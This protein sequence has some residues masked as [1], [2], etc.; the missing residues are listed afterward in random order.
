[1]NRKTA[2][3]LALL[4]AFPLAQAQ[5]APEPQPPAPQPA[6]VVSEEAPGKQKLPMTKEVVS[7]EGLSQS[8]EGYSE[9]IKNMAGVQPTNSSGSSNDAFSIR[10]IKLNLFSNYRLDGGLPVTG[11][12]TN[13]T[14]N[15]ERVET[16][17]GANALMFGI[18]SPAGIINFIPKR[19]GP[20][21]ITSVGV[22]GNGF[23]QY[24]F[25]TDIGRRFGAQKQLGLRFNA[26]A[27]HLENGVRGTGGEGHFAS[28]G[29]DYVV[30]NRLTLQA[31]LEH[32]ERKVVEQ[33]GIS[34]LAPVNGVIPI[35][36]VPDP[37]KLLSGPWDEY[38]PRTT[39]LQVRAD[40]AL[41]DNWKLL[42]QSGVS[43]SHRHRTTVRIGGYDF[44]TGANGVV[45]VQPIT[46]DY[47]NTFHRAEVLGH[48]STWGLA[49]DL[50]VGIS[51]S[52]RRAHAFDVQNLNLPQ[53][54]NIYNPIPLNAPVFT[55]AGADNPVQDSRDIGVYAYDTISVTKK[56]KLLA[57]VRLVRDEEANG[58]LTSS[59]R[60]TSPAAGVI[61][62]VTPTTS[63]FASYMQGLEAGATSP[64]NAANANVILE[65]TISRQKE[66]GIR[67][68]SIKGLALNASLFEIVRANAATDPVTNIFAYYGDL[69]YRGVEATAAWDINPRWRLNAAV[70]RLDAVQE[71]PVQPTFNGK[72]PENTPKWNG[73]V[74]LTWR[75][76]FVPGLSL[77][78]GFKAISKRPVNNANQGYIPGYTIWDA[79]AS[80]ATKVGGYKTTFNV[81]VD[82]ITNKRYWNSVQTGTYGIGMDRTIKFSA[83][84]DF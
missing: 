43:T 6:E 46:H 81:S 83:K 35:T 12:I 39:N 58:S 70:L 53:R 84:V 4:A 45:F 7:G 79:G 27:A 1:M 67:D 71:S 11:V 80:Y 40:Y 14:E 5:Q 17:K 21:D 8:Q 34:L 18:A 59:S 82:N 68:N 63:I 75:T 52:E 76:P 61:Y 64:A 65:P 47:R 32:Y 51:K 2:L 42:L 24:G 56:L 55:R 19:A 50:T 73:N 49:H 74:G 31:D 44:N 69:R 29:A 36:R 57:G 60:V 23:G 3:A 15:K 13:P 28:I 16:L 25:S 30:N 20:K 38:T 26:S 9:A 78:A 22:A 72:V 54:Q 62:D 37:R 10:G 41:A 48:F 33:A 66:V 77:K